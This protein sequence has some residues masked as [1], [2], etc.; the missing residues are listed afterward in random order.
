[1]TQDALHKPDI[2]AH[3]GRVVYG[4]ALERGVDAGAMLQVLRLSPELLE[5][6]RTR[7]SPAQLGALLR[8]VWRELDDEYMG[9]GAVPQRF[10]SFALMARHMVECASLADALSYATRFDNLTSRSLNWELQSGRETV[11]SLE[12]T[13]PEADSANFLE[14]FTLMIW[15]RFCN[16]LVGERIPLHRTWFSFVEPA[17][18]AEHR[19]MFPGRISYGHARSCICFDSRWL[20]NPVIRSRQDLLR[21][22][23]RLPDEWFI[24]QTFD[25]SISE[26][27]AAAFAEADSFPSLQTLAS[28]WH[29]SS[30]TLHRQL[31]QE[32]TS[33]RRIR[34]QV[35]RERAIALLLEGKKQVR[36]V[37]RLL[38]MTEPA[39]SRAFK[40][41]TGMTPL[42]Y[43]RARA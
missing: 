19:L 36:E 5:D 12:L 18:S 6:E 30:R 3:F 22:L 29:M 43:R 40:Q 13:A 9:F 26:K 11:L 21:Y 2:A 33:F 8:T 7:I 20:T 1:M 16:W 31:R 17:H 32:G 10:G 23:Q 39:F 15:H 25:G 35:R 4:R 38:D 41:W 34:E 37:A 24:K 27:V 42:A 14:E 28:S